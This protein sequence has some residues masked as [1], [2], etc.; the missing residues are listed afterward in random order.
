MRRLKNEGIHANS[1]FETKAAGRLSRTQEIGVQL[2]VDLLKKRECLVH[3]EPIY[4][5]N[6]ARWAIRIPRSRTDDEACKNAEPDWQK[7]LAGVA[8]LMAS[9]LSSG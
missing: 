1:R 4:R 7:P 9:L 2:Q 8:I 5:R 6:Q 3:I